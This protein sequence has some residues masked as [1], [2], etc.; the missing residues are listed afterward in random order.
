MTIE[1][2]TADP[3]PAT[4]PIDPALREAHR[5]AL[6]SHD[7]ADVADAQLVMKIRD[8]RYFDSLVTMLRI[9]RIRIEEPRRMAVTAKV[10]LLHSAEF[11]PPQSELARARG[12]AALIVD[13]LGVADGDHDAVVR[14]VLLLAHECLPSTRVRRTS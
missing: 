8:H 2:A 9:S 3:A 4:Y 14:Q 10:A 13:D 5:K 7:P 1:P 6:L 12:L 11:A